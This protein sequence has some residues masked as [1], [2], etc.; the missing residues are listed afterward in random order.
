MEGPRAND[1]PELH[2]ESMAPTLSSP[3]P[4]KPDL[5]A[6]AD[7]G[8]AIQGGRR[9]N[10][11][12][13]TS[14]ECV[15]GRYDSI[16]AGVWTLTHISPGPRANGAEVPLMPRLPGEVGKQAIEL[17]L[18]HLVALA[19]SPLDAGTIKHADLATPVANQSGIL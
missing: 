18:D 5:G 19:A 16:P 8:I 17:R 14:Y 7:E 10:A 9:D 6:A 13:R 15:M 12:G 3:E 2:V 11:R 1:W 4:V